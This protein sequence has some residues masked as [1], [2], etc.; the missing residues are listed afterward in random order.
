MV[1]DRREKSEIESPF[2]RSR[3]YI[4]RFCSSFLSQGTL[5]PCAP[6]YTIYSLL[7][8]GRR[9]LCSYSLKFP[10]KRI[11]IAL[12]FLTI[13]LVPQLTTQVATIL[14]FV[15]ADGE[16][17]IVFYII[18]TKFEDKSEKIVNLE[19]PIE[20]NIAVRSNNFEYKI[21]FSD[22]GYMNDILFE[23]IAQ[24]FMGRWKILYPGLICIVLGDNLDQHRNINV[25]IEGKNH[26]IHWWF[27]VENTTH[28]SQPLD[29]GVFARLKQ[30]LYKKIED[31]FFL[32]GF[33]PYSTKLSLIPLLQEAQKEAY[34]PEVIKK[35][36]LVT[37]IYP[38]SKKYN[39]IK[40]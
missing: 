6:N 23:E 40:V 34:T 17:I 26:D 39:F 4:V 11:L 37:G 9:L 24:I 18:R 32:T 36:F 28:W 29:N 5:R 12:C 3:H 30:I 14:P 13:P 27:L 21:L 33:K 22:T 10:N 25:I 35:A 8:I 1:L 38:F 31:K 20:S 15:N 7:R 16:V 19:L 2:P